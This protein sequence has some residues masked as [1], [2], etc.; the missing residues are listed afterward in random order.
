MASKDREQIIADWLERVERSDLPAPRFFDRYRVPFSLSQYY[1]YRKKYE[2]FGISALRDQRE[3]GNHRRLDGE[4]ET[5]LEGYV[6][7]EPSAKLET[8]QEHIRDRFDVEISLSGISRCL[9]RLGLQRNQCVALV[10]P[11]QT[12]KPTETYSPHAGFELI[13]ALACHFRWPQETARVIGQIIVTAKRSGKFADSSSGLDQSGRNRRGQFTARYNRR[14][15]VR[16]KRFES[17]DIKRETKHLESMD[18]LRSS[19]E[20]IAR[21]CLAILALPL[22][23]HNGIVRSVDSA[24]GLRL[25]TLCGF[26]YKQSTLNQFLSDLKYLGASEQLLRHQVSYWRKWWDN[27]SSND[28]SFPLLCYYVDGN[29]KAVWSSKRVKKNQV[30]MLGRV[31]GCLEQLFVHDNYGRPVYFET[32]SGHAPMGEHILSLFQ[33][34]E[35]ALAGKGP[36]LRVNRAIVMDGASNSVRTLRAFAAQKK[37]H[38]ITSLDDNQWNRRKIRHAGRPERYQYGP[39]SLRDCEIEL[40]DSQEK[41]YLFV[42]RAIHI[43]WDRGKD[44]YLITSLPSDV[45][46][47]STVVKSY[48]DRWPDQE[49]VFRAMKRVASLNRVAG[50]GKQKLTDRGVVERQKELSDKIHQLHEKLTEPRARIR[51]LE[52]QIDGLIKD[53][54]PLKA[55][56]RVKDGRRHLPKREMEQLQQIGR[57]ISKVERQI[58]SIR[59][60]DPAFKQLAKS[61]REW[62][63]LQG[64]ETVYRVDVELDQIITYFRASLVNLEA[65]LATMMG[66]SRLSL[67]TLMANVLFLPGKIIETRTRKEIHLERNEYDPE[68]MQRLSSVLPLLNNMKSKTLRGQVISFALP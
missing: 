61:E 28:P 45:I 44:T 18:L 60:S 37:Y 63:R 35:G 10:K 62:M 56:S 4:V 8:I 40:E 14:R 25:G 57:Q 2:E 42:T 51:V 7:A 27:G 26:R 33:K 24:M 5:Y 49:L 65:H 12:A 67:S 19:R 3:S 38:Y 55:K 9:K 23:T 17:V 59:K 64:K 52:T 30:T 20:A 47:M 11:T 39:A 68:T 54:Q 48:F 29:T 66:V 6:A 21:K 31:M 41:G 46:G 1:V 22:V 36:K 43:H 32:Y 16:E 15:D 58:K 53:E 34:I 13:M 50:Y